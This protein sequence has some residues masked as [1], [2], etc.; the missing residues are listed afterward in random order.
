VV[1]Y[2]GSILENL[3]SMRASLQ[4]A[5]YVHDLVEHAPLLL[6]ELTTEY[7]L[8]FFPLA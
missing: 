7:L 2:A 4:V 6:L 8:E 1:V 3:A 5:L